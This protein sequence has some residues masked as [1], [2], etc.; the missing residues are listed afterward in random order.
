MDWSKAHWQKFVKKHWLEV[1]GFIVAIIAL[2]F[3]CRPSE[4]FG[5][6]SLEFAENIS[7][8]IF[9]IGLGL[10]ALKLLIDYYESKRWKYVQD[11]TSRTI[12]RLVDDITHQIRGAESHF[13]FNLNLEPAKCGTDV[14]K[15]FIDLIEAVDPTDDNMN[16][17]DPNYRFTHSGLTNIADDLVKCVHRNVLYDLD[18][19]QRNLIPRILGSPVDQDIKDLL[20][21]LDEVIYK[22]KEIN[23]PKKGGVTP[24]IQLYQVG[25]LKIIIKMYE[26]ALSIK[27]ELNKEDQQKK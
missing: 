12:V 16:D 1:F 20:I 27:R 11:V 3:G 26:L 8:E 17:E 13:L 22:F 23:M 24:F 4:L 19:L 5:I 25:Q 21:N 10:S 2:I 18:E 14:L 6:M 15:K 9:G 7:A